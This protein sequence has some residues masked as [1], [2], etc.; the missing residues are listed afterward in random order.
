MA[1]EG[2][3]RK[4]KGQQAAWNEE[5]LGKE[6]RESFKEFGMGKSRERKS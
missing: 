6:V 1:K 5:E 3:K 2:L 4:F